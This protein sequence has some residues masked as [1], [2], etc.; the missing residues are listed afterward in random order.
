MF[1]PPIMM[2]QVFRY[3]YKQQTGLSFI[4]ICFIFLL[5]F[6]RNWHCVDQ[7]TVTVDNLMCIANQYSFELFFWLSSKSQCIFAYSIDISAVAATLILPII[8]ICIKRI[9]LWSLNRIFGIH[10]IMLLQWYLNDS[11]NSD[12]KIDLKWNQQ[13]LIMIIAFSFG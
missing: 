2:L 8:I 6:A 7:G 4:F 12:G 5:I 1:R 9:Y 3:I 13:L 10:F 11:Q